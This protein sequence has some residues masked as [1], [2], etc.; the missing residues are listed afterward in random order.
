VGRLSE[1][2]AQPTNAVSV[3]RRRQKKKLSR[4]IDWSAL[5]AAHDALRDAHFARH[6][7]ESLSREV[8]ALSIVA[9]KA[10]DTAREKL[11]TAERLVAVFEEKSSKRH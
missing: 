10:I 11:A 6:H 1:N 7:A 9:S 3:M 4:V 5:T 2:R 8:V